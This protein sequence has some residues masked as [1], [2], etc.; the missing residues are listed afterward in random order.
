MRTGRL[1]V[2]IPMHLSR[3]RLTMERIIHNRLLSRIL[4]LALPLLLLIFRH[5]HLLLLLRHHPSFFITCHRLLFILLFRVQ[6]RA[7][8]PTRP[9]TTRTRCCRLLLQQRSP[10]RRALTDRCLHLLRLHRLHQC[11]HQQRLQVHHVKV[12][13]SF[14]VFLFELLNDFKQSVLQLF[15]VLVLKRPTAKLRLLVRFLLFLLL[16]LLCQCKLRMLLLKSLAFRT[17]ANPL[18]GVLCWCVRT[19]MEQ[20]QQRK[21]NTVLSQKHRFHLSSA[22]FVIE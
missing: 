6:R 12:S 8:D 10:V 13:V 19:N 2:M 9:P 14:F 16:F 7:R 3:A 1:L 17:Q 18:L 21:E 22:G 5:R 15:H 11:H 20:R 4:L